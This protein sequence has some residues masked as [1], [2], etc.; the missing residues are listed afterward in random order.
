MGVAS[1]CG[2]QEVG[3][4]SGSG[5]N[6]WVWLLGVVVRRYIDFLILLIPTPLV[7]VLLCKSIV[8]TGIHYLSCL[9]TML[10]S[11]NN[12]KITFTIDVILL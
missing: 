7:S 9:Y 12:F 3:V 4:A 2:E 5:W 10:I 1:G 11:V 6:L 8:Y